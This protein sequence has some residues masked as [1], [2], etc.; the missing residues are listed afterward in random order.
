VRRRRDDSLFVQRRRHPSR[1]TIV[2][3]EDFC[4]ILAL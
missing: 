4:H 1:L 3:A 2:E